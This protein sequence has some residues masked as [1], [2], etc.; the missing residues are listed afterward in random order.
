MDIETHEKIKQ[1]GAF[2]EAYGDVVK[3]LVN[4]YIERQQ[5][6]SSLKK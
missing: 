3:R 4:D 1:I 6:K 2:G 5:P